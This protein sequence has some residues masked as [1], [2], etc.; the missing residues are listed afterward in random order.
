MG[1]GSMRDRMLR[2]TVV[3]LNDGCATYQNSAGLPVGNV[4]VMVD[5]NLQRTGPEGVFATDQ[6][7]ITWRKV[8]M[9]SAMRGGIFTHHGKRYLVED[10][11]A[12]DGHMLT[13]ACMEAP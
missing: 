1:W 4:L 3:V 5:F 13:A 7:G 11:I 6:V 9:P 10:L 12:D 2:T 8:E